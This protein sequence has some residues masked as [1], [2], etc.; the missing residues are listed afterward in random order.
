MTSTFVQPLGSVEPG[1]R[2][3]LTRPDWTITGTFDV[4]TL[5]PV[6]RDRVHLVAHNVG[7]G[8]PEVVDGVFAG[9]LSVGVVPREKTAM[10]EKKPVV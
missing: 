8:S 10:G 2:I 4:E 1:Q 6:D 9:D 5:Q 7:G 3:V